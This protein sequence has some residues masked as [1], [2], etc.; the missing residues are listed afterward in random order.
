MWLPVVILG[1]WK[2][3]PFFWCTAIHIRVIAVN[4]LTLPVETV[5]LGSPRCLMPGQGLPTKA[6]S[7]ALGQCWMHVFDFTG[8][9]VLGF[10][11][12]REGFRLENLLG[13]GT[14]VFDKTVPGWAYDCRLVW[15]EL[16]LTW[17]SDENLG[18]I[19]PHND[20]PIINVTLQI[21]SVIII[22]SDY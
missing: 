4:V 9:R 22:T 5:A 12:F 16:R 7:A 18:H 1:S 3:A 11:G 10:R 21:N 17:S 15:M 6:V 2:H 20:I 8:I 14:L 13:R 19:H